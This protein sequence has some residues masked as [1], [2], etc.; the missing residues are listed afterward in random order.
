MGPRISVATVFRN[1]GQ[2]NSGPRS[3]GPI[4]E[5]LSEGNPPI[6][7]ETTLKDYVS[8]THSK[9]LDG[10]SGVLEHLKLLWRILETSIY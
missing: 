1:M 7:K 6:Y 10:K 8:L 5:L 3:Y 2:G 9:G 4:K